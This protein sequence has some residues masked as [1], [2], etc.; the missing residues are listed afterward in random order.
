[1]WKANTYI[2]L[3]A[4][5]QEKKQYLMVIL[6]FYSVIIEW[7]FAGHSNQYQFYRINY[8][9]NIPITGALTSW[10]ALSDHSP[11]SITV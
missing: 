11:C 4:R 3:S 2:I 7:P 6:F 1:M 10:V 5:V 8:L 9:L